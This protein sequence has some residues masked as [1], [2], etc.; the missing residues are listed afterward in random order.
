MKVI[1]EVFNYII[2]KI[3]QNLF[4]FFFTLYNRYTFHGK[5]YIPRKHVNGIIIASN[6]ASNMDPML[7]GL[8]MHRRIHFLAKKSLFKGFVG[9]WTKSVGAFPVDR[10]DVAPSSL[11]KIISILKEGKTLILFPEGTRSENGE[12]QEFKKGIGLIAKKTRSLVIPSYIKGSYRML[13]KGSKFPKPVKLTTYYGK[14]VDL[15][16]LYEDEDTDREIVYQKIA[17]RIRS[18]VVELKE[19]SER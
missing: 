3:S 11:K 5:R 17:E 7:A 13:P 12:L 8:P 18:R 19:K 14:P 9:W 6:H 1:S 16:D 4:L 2:Y 10:E 15:N